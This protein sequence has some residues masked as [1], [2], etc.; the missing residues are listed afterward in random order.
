MSVQPLYDA[1][2]RRRSP[3]TTPGFRAGIAP[4]NKG[5]RYPADPPT[6][7][8]I[9]AVM[10]QAGHDRHGHRLTALVVVLWRAGLRIHEAL[11]L[12]ETDLD[13]RRGSI[14]VRHGK[15]DRRREVG[16]D[17][18]GWTAIEPWLADRVGLPVGPRFC[19]IDG[20][21]RGRAWSDSAARVELRHLALMAGVRRRFAPHQLR[22]AH[23][24][25]LMREG[26]PLPLIQRQL[27]HSH[28][29]TTG[30]YLEGINT[31]EIIST[32]HARRAPMM[33]ASAGLA[34]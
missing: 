14:L 32:V 29:S 11:C 19:V 34:L 30:T 13:P 22:H 7:E 33:H 24:V 18:W 6:V 25:E 23:A 28:L 17:A 3:A 20:P 16:M 4:R 10:R 8:E 26:I 12:T 31:E 2:G 15:N 1:T 21:T 27:G 9:V 5:Q